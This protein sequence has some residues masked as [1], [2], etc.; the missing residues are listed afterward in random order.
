VATGA[1]ILCPTTFQHLNNF[2]ILIMIV[3]S[4]VQRTATGGT[5]PIKLCTSVD[6]CTMVQKRLGRFDVPISDGLLHNINPLADMTNMKL[7]I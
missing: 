1:K 3:N 5:P 2:V 6:I 7:F 4:P